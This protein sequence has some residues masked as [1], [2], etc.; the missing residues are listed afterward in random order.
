MFYQLTDH[1]IVSAP[2]A[3]TWDFFSTA[4]NLP[5][6]TPSWLRFTVRT[7]GPVTIGPDSV[8]DYTIRWMGLPIRWTTKTLRASCS[9]NCRAKTLS[10]HWNSSRHTWTRSRRR[11]I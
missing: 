1:F 8:L 6:I 2:L 4:S 3:R 11:T 5:L 10:L 9:K 7:P